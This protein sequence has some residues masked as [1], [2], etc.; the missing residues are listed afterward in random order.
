L[1]RYSFSTWFG[2]ARLVADDGDLMTIGVSDDLC[3][4]WIC[5][6]YSGALLDALA[7]AGR[8]DVA[9]RVVVNEDV[10]YD[11]RDADSATGPAVSG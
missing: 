4:D 11:A 8:P 7:E 2:Q 5:R 6:Q 3:A 10:W 9:I 1:N